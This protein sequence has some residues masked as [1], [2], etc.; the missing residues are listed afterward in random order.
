MTVLLE[1]V[2]SNINIACNNSCTACNHLVVPQRKTAH[3]WNMTPEQLGHD[4]YEFGKV[5]RI[6]KYAFIGGEPTLHPML[7]ELAFVARSFP[8]VFDE[9]EIWTNGQT[10]GMQ[11]DWFWQAFD[12]IIVSA[13]PGKL[14]DADIEWMREQCAA[15]NT[16]F[17]LKDERNA[18]YFTRLLEPKPTDKWQTQAKYN[19]CWYRT[20]TRVLD[21]G[22]FYRCCTSPFIPSVIQGLPKEIDGIAVEGLTEDGLLDFLNQTK[23]ATA[24]QMCAGHGANA[25]PW[26]E[27]RDPQKWLE[28]SAR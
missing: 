27:E 5:A 13:Y 18:P 6:R 28:M 23:P 4:L 3:R 14:T 25:I 7:R 1:H 16:A 19:A 21:W 15:H 12:R 20:Y 24:C 17:E 11:G 26:A 10:L 2:E 8:N 22:Y 9:L